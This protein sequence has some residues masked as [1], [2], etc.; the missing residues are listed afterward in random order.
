[1]LKHI[2]KTLHIDLYFYKNKFLFLGSYKYLEESALAADY[3]IKGA[4]YLIQSYFYFLGL[5]LAVALGGIARIELNYC[6][7]VKVSL[8][9]YVSITL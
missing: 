7:P 3:C 4:C 8:Q 5:G 2:F 1:M 6:I 9:F